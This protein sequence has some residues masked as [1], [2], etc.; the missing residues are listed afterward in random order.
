M[1]IQLQCEKNRECYRMNGHAGKCRPIT[2]GHT[3]P[4]DSALDSRWPTHDKTSC[5]DE[6]P[7]NAGSDHGACRRCTAISLQEL[8]R[9]KRE[10]G[11]DDL[12]KHHLRQSAL[13]EQ[14]FKDGVYGPAAKAKVQ[15]F[16][17]TMHGDSP[18]GKALHLLRGSQYKL[19][20]AEIK[21]VAEKK[22]AKDR[23][24]EI[25]ELQQSG[26]GNPHLKTKRS[27]K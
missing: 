4:P 9:L 6:N 17:N 12:F 7:C 19:E 20:E 8:D 14:E 25:W 27:T 5:S 18:V 16:M 24:R 10:A 21:R 11:H 26:Q 15:W 13:L 1:S 22:A 23:R 3:H 2:R